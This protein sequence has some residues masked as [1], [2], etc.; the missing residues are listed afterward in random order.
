[1]KKIALL[2]FI[3]M[4]IAFGKISA[5]ESHGGKPMTFDVSVSGNTFSKIKGVFRINT[6][7]LP[8]LDNT[9]EA[10]EA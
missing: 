6:N 8:L 9:F 2:L 7:Q 5:Q 4:L 10:M 3:C 1:M